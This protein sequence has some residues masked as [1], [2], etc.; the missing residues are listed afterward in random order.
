M[1]LYKKRSYLTNSLKELVNTKRPLLAKHNFNPINGR[2][3]S[4]YYLT[5][6]GARFL[7]E[8]LDYNENKIKVPKGLVPIYLRE[9]SHRKLTIDFH[10]YL[11][12]WI[13]TN[14]G[15]INFLNYYFDKKGNNRSAN[16]A[17]YVTALNRIH[18]DKKNSFIPDI[19]TMFSVNNKKYLYLFEQ[20]NGK[21][22][23]RLFKQLYIHILAISKGVVSEKYNIKKSH[24]VVVVCE[25]E[26]VKQSVIKRF[27]KEKGIERYNNLFIFKTNSELEND[28]YKNWTKISGEQT[29]FIVSRSH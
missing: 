20:H 8:E 23:K 5:K 13:K 28:F 12:Q 6:Y 16:S 15:E 9:Y 19:N 21:D 10:I 24:V 25:H 18:L 4:Y 14:N 2:L 27:Q 29:D 11:N 3:E 1:G 7:I 17:D 22:T 26:S